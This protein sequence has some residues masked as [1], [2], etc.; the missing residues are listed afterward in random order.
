[1]TDRG[2]LRRRLET[3][4]RLAGDRADTAMARPV[5]ALDFLST[6]LGDSL[7]PKQGKSR[8]V[9]IKCRIQSSHY[10][11]AEPAC[12]SGLRQAQ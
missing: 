8:Y 5:D 1:M 12:H 4:K 9:E 10:L 6:Y 11:G 2:Q 7:S 3:A